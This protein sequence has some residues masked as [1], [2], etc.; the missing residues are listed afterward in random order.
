[1]HRPLLAA[2]A[3]VL[4][5]PAGAQPLDP[6]PRVAVMSAYAPEWTLLTEALEGSE[7]HVA[8][9]TRFLTGTLEG[10][11]VVLFLSGIS[12]VNAAMTT[13]MALDA[14]EVEAILFSGI[15]GGVDPALGIGDVVIAERWGQYMDAALAR[16]TP[17]GFALPPWMTSDFPPHG[18]IHTRAVDV[19]SARAPAP[20]SRFWFEADPALLDLA[21]EAVAG[22]ELEG[23]MA[24]DTC[25][26]ESPTALVGGNGVSG[27]VFVDNADF[28]E[29]AFDA[30]DA[31]VLDMESA[32]VA[33]VAYV[34]EVPFLAVR[35]L[36]DLAGG[37]EGENEIGTFLGLAAANSATVVR[38][39]LSAMD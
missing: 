16:E 13:Q 18:M 39:I 21:R 2:L 33:H 34:N 14:F 7:E 11:E 8:N 28:R 17:G 32:A 29:W 35:S 26:S 31:R 27:S 20:E 36:S 38:A 4:A 3:V 5:A 15:A 9:G 1:M 24:P 22:L 6:A 12:M 10:R 37:G 25:L 30:F 19:Q 23:C